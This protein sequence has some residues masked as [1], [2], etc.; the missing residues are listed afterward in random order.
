M[1]WPME[2][3]IELQS[4]RYA[5]MCK[6]KGHVWPWSALPPRNVRPGPQ[7]FV[8]FPYLPISDLASHCFWTNSFNVPVQMLQVSL[9]KTKPCQGMSRLPME[10]LEVS[11]IWRTVTSWI[12]C[13]IQWKVLLPQ[14]FIRTGSSAYKIKRVRTLYAFVMIRVCVLI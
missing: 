1:Y 5:V 6:I 14:V 8:S 4:T 13:V 3:K 10:V 11:V 9:V 7:S 12:S 2:Y